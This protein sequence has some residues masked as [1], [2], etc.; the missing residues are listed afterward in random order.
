MKFSLTSEFREKLK[1][2]IF[3]SNKQFI[4]NVFK[5]VSY[6]DITELL[7]EFNWSTYENLDDGSVN[8]IASG[9]EEIDNNYIIYWLNEFSDTILI[10]DDLNNSSILDTLDKT[11]LTLS[12]NSFSLFIILRYF[13]S[14]ILFFMDAALIPIIKNTSN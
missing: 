7:Y 4:K 11:S 8:V 5:D 12:G 13:V 1:L 2:E 14:E 9:V 10:D 6:V 3:N